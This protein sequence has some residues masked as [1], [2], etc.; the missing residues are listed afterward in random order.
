MKERDSMEFV[1]IIRFGEIWIKGR[2]RRFFEQALETNIRR[3]LKRGERAFQLERE[4]GR[5]YVLET[6]DDPAETTVLLSR[7]PGIVSVSVGVRCEKSVKSLAENG[8]ALMRTMGVAPATFKVESKRADKTFPIPSPQL[9]REVAEYL[10][11][12][13]L[14]VPVDVHHP[15]MVFGVEIQQNGAY[16]FCQTLRGAGGLPTG[17][18]GKVA[19]L[20]SGGIDSPVA[21]YQMQKRGA[22]VEPVYF[23]GFPFTSD[24][25]KDKV[26]RLAEKLAF[27]QDSL[28]LH[29]VNF[30][31]VLTALKAHCP[32]KFTIIVMRR[33]MV[34]IAAEIAKKTGCRALV[35]GD[36]LGQ[37]ASQTLDNL[38]CV[39]DA[40]PMMIFRP[41]LSFDKFE[42]IERAKKI[43]TYE[44]SIEPHEDCCALFVPKFPEIYGKL[45][46]VREAESAMD[47]AGLVEECSVSVEKVEF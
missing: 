22:T 38:E 17:V 6:A 13:G 5:L 43:D 20:L 8:L 29:I 12:H 36:N 3:T 30:T 10:L 24:M 4:R 41:L 31:P 46:E 32:E 1:Y 26:A 37:V 11:T 2:N 28:A 18:S 33:F 15:E 40:S 47:V 45:D 44:V 9:S 19:V 23:H 14:D 16:A 27:Y 42:I 34:R 21:G 35:T 7:I 25:V 39:T